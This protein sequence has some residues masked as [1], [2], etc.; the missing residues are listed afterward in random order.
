VDYKEIDK[1]NKNDRFKG[2]F[3]VLLDDIV[4]KYC[5]EEYEKGR[6]QRHPFPF[7]TFTLERFQVL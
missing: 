4:I 1:D 5:R 7:F 3:E 2:W 6:T